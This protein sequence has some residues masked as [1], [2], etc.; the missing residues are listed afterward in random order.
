MNKE[1]IGIL[2]QFLLEVQTSIYHVK[3]HG[4]S[5]WKS[6]C[7]LIGI[8]RVIMIIWNIMLN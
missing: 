5:R 3:K 1:G 2:L 7:F 8:S 6:P 4:I